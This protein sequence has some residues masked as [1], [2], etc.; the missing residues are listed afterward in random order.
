MPLLKKWQE[1]V[2]QTHIDE[3][4]ALRAA[5]KHLRKIL[6]KF[7]NG[8]YDRNWGE[9]LEDMAILGDHLSNAHT[10]S[11]KCNDILENNHKPT[12]DEERWDFVKAEQE[13]GNEY[14]IKGRK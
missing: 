3:G 1:I 6:R 12:S 9:F 2:R 11:K 10:L 5:K 4:V 13:R 8:E 7:G 14:R